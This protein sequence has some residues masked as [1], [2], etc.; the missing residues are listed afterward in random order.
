MKLPTD[1]TLLLKIVAGLA[2][3]LLLLDYVVVEP[4][5]GSWSAQSDRIAALQKKVN[6][7]QN[8]LD[9]EDRIRN[10]WAAMQRANLPVDH[11][12]AEA[13]AL[14]AINRWKADSGITLTNW[15]PQWQ[16]LEDEGYDAFECR[17]AG[18][19]D[20]V[21]IGRFLF[22]L[23]TDALPCNLEECEISTRDAHGQQLTMTARFSFARVSPDIRAGLNAGRSGGV[24]KGRS[25]NEE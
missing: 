21:S 5:V 14:N 25:T 6:R 17:V 20:Q 23:N 3:G 1:R 19:G 2:A 15:V 10:V 9:R 13:A 8:L 22:D 12:A 18:T 11:S 7:G 4:A 24:G 16:S